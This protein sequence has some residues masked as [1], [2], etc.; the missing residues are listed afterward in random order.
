[1]NPS[2]AMILML[3]M[4]RV[5]LVLFIFSVVLTGALYLKFKRTLK[6]DAKCP[7]IWILSFCFTL[8][9]SGFLVGTMMAYVIYP[10]LNHVQ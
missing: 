7:L 3:N 1:V 4:I 5:F 6:S 8:L 9:M 2:N 10:I